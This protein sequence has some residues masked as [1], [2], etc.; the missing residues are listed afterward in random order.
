MNQHSGP[1]A[2]AERSL[3][4]LHCRLHAGRAAGGSGPSD[5]PARMLGT[6][7]HR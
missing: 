5:R 1:E 6:K 4:L 7:S 3:G 2:F